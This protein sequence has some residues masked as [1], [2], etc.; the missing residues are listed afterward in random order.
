[1]RLKRTKLFALAATIAAALALAAVGFAQGGGHGGPGGPGGPHGSLV[2]HLS[3]AVNLTDAQKTQIKQI[4]DS[5]RESTKPLHEQLMKAGDGG[6]FDG[7][8]DTFDEAAVRAAAQARAT[9]HVELDVAHARMMSQVYAVL[10]A[11]Q[12]AKLAELRQQFE[13]RR[14]G[15][16]P[17]EDGGQGGH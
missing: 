1:M 3:H 8:T 17:G 6:P 13:Q 2:E 14:P 10:T 5:F 9:L 11:E 12:R 16:P 4:E 15:P 7:F